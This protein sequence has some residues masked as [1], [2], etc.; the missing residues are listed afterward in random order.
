MATAVAAAAVVVGA[1]IS[2]KGSKSA[3]AT[4]ARA[5]TEAADIQ[6]RQFVETKEQLQPFIE[7]GL[8]AQQLQA[9]LSGALGTEAQAAAFQSFQE[10]PG[11]QF[12]REQGLRLVNTG[13]AATGG[14]GG[15][16]RLRELTRFSQGLA[17]QDFQNQFNRLGAVT[18]TGLSAA[19]AIGGV[20]T[21]AAVGQAQSLQAAGAASAAGTLGSSQ[22]IASGIGTLGGIFAGSINSG[23]NVSGVS[24]VSSGSVK[25]GEIFGG[26]R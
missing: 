15:G 21:A 14:L 20:G 19:Q 4:T 5:A 16:E 24:G 12:L 25:P 26:A 22:A 7:P 6:R 10:S 23:S 2:S 3:A 1:I 13:A 9:A 8:K 18:G 11:T 17:L